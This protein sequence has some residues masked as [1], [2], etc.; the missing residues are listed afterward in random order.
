M[1]IKLLTVLGT[2]ALA[3]VLAFIVV[4]AMFWM[5]DIADNIAI[6]RD[7]QRDKAEHK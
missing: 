5:M 3:T 4:I 6:W 2:L 7:E 1:I